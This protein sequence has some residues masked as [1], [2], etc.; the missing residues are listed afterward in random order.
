MAFEPP[1]T[2]AIATSGSRPSTASDLRRGLVAD[3]PLEVAHERGVR[4]RADRRPEHVVG[5]RDVRDPVAHRLVD[6]VLEGGRARGHLADLGAQRPH[7]Q[8]VRRLAADVLSTHVDDASRSRS[9][10]AVAVATPCWPAR[11]RR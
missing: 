4:M 9:A 5:G 10:Q 7:P 1:P 6:G 11:S 3:D 2:Q 8:H